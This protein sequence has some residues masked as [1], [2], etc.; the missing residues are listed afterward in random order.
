M[1]TSINCVH[2]TYHRLLAGFNS[3]LQSYD[4]PLFDDEASISVQNFVHG[5][6]L[7]I[8]FQCTC[9][10]LQECSLFD[11]NLTWR[12][13]ITYLIPFKNIFYI[14][15]G[16]CTCAN[17]SGTC[18]IW[19]IL[20]HVLCMCSQYKRQAHEIV[21][22][23]WMREKKRKLYIR[24]EDHTSRSKCQTLTPSPLL[25]LTNHKL[26]KMGVQTHLLYNDGQSKIRAT[27]CQEIHVICISFLVSLS[28]C[29][30][31]KRNC[32]YPNTVCYPLVWG[33]WSSKRVRPALFHVSLCVW[34]LPRLWDALSVREKSP[35][36]YH[37]FYGH[38]LV[39]INV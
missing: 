22:E 39:L 35:W 11:A 10:V 1:L 30:F 31:E 28:S 37:S 23:N 5:V 29:E 18:G 2:Y 21:Y 38:C 24:I 17:L 4:T 25:S 9:L 3:E 14:L 7:V 20:C 15:Y 36:P 34:K 13:Q 19:R 32:N 33:I 12:I 27:V 26:T 8:Q 6:I 16:L